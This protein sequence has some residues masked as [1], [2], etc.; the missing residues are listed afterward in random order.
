[1][2]PSPTATRK[3]VV[4]PALRGRSV[5]VAHRLGVAV[6]RESGDARAHRRGGCSDRER[7]RDEVADGLPAAGREH[8][9]GALGAPLALELGEGVGELRQQR[10]GLSV[11]G[12]SGREQ[13]R[14]GVQMLVEKG[15]DF[16]SRHAT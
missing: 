8:A 10:L 11:A 3:P 16:E 6:D 13:G 9:G 15:D 5:E 4:G 14:G 7:R 2:C 1:M 12:V